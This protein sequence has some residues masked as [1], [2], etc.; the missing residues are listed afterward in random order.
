[1]PTRP[2]AGP[3]TTGLH[4]L[5]YIFGPLL[6]LL[7]WSPIA[8]TVIIPIHLPPAHPNRQPF[9][10]Q[11]HLHNVETRFVPRCFWV[12]ISSIGMTFLNSKRPFGAEKSKGVASTHLKAQ[13]Q[14]PAAPSFSPES[15]RSWGSSPQRSCSWW[16]A[17][18]AAPCMPEAL[19]AWN[20]ACQLL[21]RHWCAGCQTFSTNRRLPP[22]HAVHC[23]MTSTTIVVNR[24]Q[25]WM[26]E[27]CWPQSE[28]DPK[29]T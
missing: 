19:S 12:W 29:Q 14:R 21:C 16:S 5:V 20:A 7:S 3:V 23:C 15:W 8:H 17:W 27:S 22:A 11:K 6:R 1:M 13:G 25:H 9:I 2:Y 18:C 4:T 24:C 10:Q 28:C 26:Q